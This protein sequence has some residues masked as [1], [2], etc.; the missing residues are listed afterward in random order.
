M[1]LLNEVRLLGNTFLISN[2]ISRPGPDGPLSAL[3]QTDN[4]DHSQ[5]IMKTS[6]FI[7]FLFVVLGRLSAA[8]VVTEASRMAEV[9]F[10]SAKSYADPFGG[11]TLDAVFTTPDG[12]LLRVPAFWAGGNS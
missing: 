1:K 7:L 8:P 6:F 5:K 4:A 3:N 11:V 12:R 2:T 10:E 9:S